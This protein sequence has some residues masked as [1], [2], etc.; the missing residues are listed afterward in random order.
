ML[1]NITVEFTPNE[2][3][4]T[5]SITYATSGD[6][7]TLTSSATSGVTRLDALDDVVEG[8]SPIDKSTLVYNAATDK[9][10]VKVLDLD[11][12]TF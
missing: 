5:T 12:G 9:Y 3:F 1:D 7:L 2:T 10:E 4:Q 11:G 8:S 6:P